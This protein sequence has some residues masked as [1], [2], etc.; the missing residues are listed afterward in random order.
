MVK[1]GQ[2]DLRGSVTL[3]TKLYNCPACMEGCITIAFR[4][5]PM[6]GVR[7][8]W[9]TLNNVRDMSEVGNISANPN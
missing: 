7:L 3:Y 8:G 6:C 4:Y 5:C 2:K 9:E 1:I